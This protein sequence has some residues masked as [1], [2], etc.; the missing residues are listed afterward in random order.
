MEFVAS[1]NPTWVLNGANAETIIT[2]PIVDGDSAEVVI[3]LRVLPNATAA[4]MTNYA[5]IKYFEDEVGDDVT[6]R[7]IDSTPDDDA[8]NDIGGDP[9]TSNDDRTDDDGTE[10]EDDHD[11]AV[12]QVFDL[13]LVKRTAQV[14]P[15]R[16]GDDVTFTLTVLNQGNV[17][18]QNIEVNEYIPRDISLSPAD[19]NSD[20]RLVSLRPTLL[21]VQLFQ[22]ISKY[23]NRIARINWCKQR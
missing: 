18:A 2:T 11:G 12:P 16:V 14:I 17:V 23:S 4:T 13:A 7:E 20:S 15:V 22:E 8:T 5:E 21:L 3:F 9:N 1:A 19:L 6:D 10:D